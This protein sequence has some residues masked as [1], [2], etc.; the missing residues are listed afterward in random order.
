MFLHVCDSVH[1]GGLR[2]GEP[3]SRETPLVGRPGK[4]SPPSRETPWQGEPPQQGDTP[5]RHG[6][7]PG[8]ENPPR[9]GEPTQYNKVDLDKTLGFCT[10]FSDPNETQNVPA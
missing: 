9:Q 7:S 4:E 1:R 3:P 2:Q 10:N 6:D 5:P 8:R